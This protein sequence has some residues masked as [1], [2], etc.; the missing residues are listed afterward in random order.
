MET[1]LAEVA[2]RLRTKHPD[3][4]NQVTVIFNNRR[5][6]L[7]LRRQFAS[8]GGQPFFLPRIMGIDEL[9]S[10]L[11]GL[12]II[13]NEYLLFE[14]FDI[15]RHLDEANDKY[16]N[17]EDFISFGEMMLADFSEIDLYCVDAQSLFSNLHDIKAIEKWNVETG[18]PTP[19]QEKYLTFYQSLYQYYT[20][21]HKRLIE[22]RQAYGG[23]AYRHVAENI[24]ALAPNSDNRYYYF[25]GFNAISACEKLIIKHYLRQGNGTFITDGDAYYYDD[26]TQEAGHF[27]RDNPFLTGEYPAHF[28]MEH[29]EI[30]IV[31]CPENVLQSKYAGQQLAQQ[32]QAHPDNPIEQTAIVLADESLLLPVLNALP[33]EIKTANVTMGYPFSNTAVHS[34]VLK[35]FALHQRRREALF[36]HTD[37]LD[38]LSDNGIATIL[39]INNIH[40]QLSN[41]LANSHIIYA[42]DEEITDLCRQLACDPTPIR[43]LFPHEIP[44]PD[45]FLLLLRQLIH[46]LYDIHAL[47]NDRKEKEALACLLRIVDYFQELQK[48]YHFVDNLNTLLKIYTR[49]AQRNSVPFYGEPLQGLQILGVLETRN[50]DFKRVIL[51]SANEG[52]LPS[53]KTSNTLIPYDLKVNF[54]IPTFHEK[55]AVYAYNFYR[56]LQRA[57]DVH[58]VYHTETEGIG[59]GE[60]SRFLLQVRRELAQRYPDNIAL[61]EEILFADSHAATTTVPPTYPKNSIILC[62]LE[63]I[64]KRGF[65]PSALNKYRSCPVRFYYEN[66][67][68]IKGNDPMNDDLEQNELGSCIHAVLEKIYSPYIGMQITSESLKEALGKVDNLLAEVLDQ[69]FHHGRSHEG[70]NHF[71]ESV[72]KIQITNFLKSEIRCLDRGEEIQ[73]LAL[74]KELSHTIQ[75]TIGDSAQHVIIAGTADRIDNW[76]GYTR[77]IDYKSGKVDS[78]DLIVNESEPNWANVSDKWFQV[79]IYT[80]LAHHVGQVGE[81]YLSG[82]YPLGHLQSELLVAQWEGSTVLTPKHLQSFEKILHELI[83]DIFNPDI[84]FIANPESKSCAHCPFAEICRRGS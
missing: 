50:L 69:Q 79:M 44:T 45:D 84:P 9:I 43:F 13:P 40:S 32:I 52:C 51:L 17:F 2:Q 10:E 77:I 34:L 27:L 80:W 58:L 66:I 4:L 68:N 37:I 53:G 38:T 21:L 74:E 25:V 16:T 11:G 39:G 67:L 59:K 72:A 7:F 83:T 70:R 62:Q 75:A 3:D 78:K 1:F 49:L 57:T 14:L 48:Q 42:T 8:M 36:Y 60:P 81:H 73:I 33:Q 63:Q 6:G 47:D 55:E 28:A 22:R 19:F 31:S 5:S 20:Q 76:N 64:A 82:I 71:F 54:G 41:L 15:H 35:L 18:Q 56:L 24:D 26:S 29:K 61:H 12:T 65:S 46:T 30:T 23:M